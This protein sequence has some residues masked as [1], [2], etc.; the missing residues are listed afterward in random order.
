HDASGGGSTKVPEREAVAGTPYRG[1]C[2]SAAPT[3]PERSS[4]RFLSGRVGCSPVRH[5]KAHA[6]PGVPAGSAPTAATLERL[7]QRGGDRVQRPIVERRVSVMAQQRAARFA[8]LIGPPV[9][10]QV[11]SGGFDDGRSPAAAPL[12]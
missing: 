1:G 3:C 7:P 2:P 6:S 11:S 9:L 12:R 8:P 5:K 10:P 4:P